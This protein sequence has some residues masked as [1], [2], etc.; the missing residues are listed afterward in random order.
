MFV[1]RLDE[2][3]DLFDDLTPLPDWIGSDGARMAWALQAVLALADAAP[4][5]RWQG[6]MRHLPAVGVLPDPPYTATYLVVKQDNNGDTFLISASSQVLL[7]RNHASA[8]TGHRDIDCGPPPT[9]NDLREAMQQ[10]AGAPEPALK[11]D[12]GDPPF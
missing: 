3:I 6:G 4:Q 11:F 8:E 7:F 12:P 10:P 2:Q 1:V 5:V 9:S